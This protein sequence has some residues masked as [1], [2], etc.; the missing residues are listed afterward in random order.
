M[1]GTLTEAEVLVQLK[2]QHD[3]YLTGATGTPVQDD[4]DA[5]VATANATHTAKANA[6]FDELNSEDVEFA[7]VSAK[8]YTGGNVV[9]PVSA[10]WME[11][12]VRAALD[13]DELFAKGG[14]YTSNYVPLS[15]YLDPLFLIEAQKLTGENMF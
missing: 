9:T 8:T 2:E 14:P 10:T 4:Q 15:P 13:N 11:A 7:G 5:R 12:Q 3:Q 6:D 1:A